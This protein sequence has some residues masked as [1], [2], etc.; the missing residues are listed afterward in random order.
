MTTTKLG[1]KDNLE[2]VA[3][4]DD[5]VA[6]AATDPIGNPGMNTM[7]DVA[8][9]QQSQHHA[10]L[11]W[12]GMSKVALPIVIK[13]RDLGDFNTSAYVETFVSLANPQV[14]GIH[15]S[16]LYLLLVEFAD[17]QVLTVTSLAAFLREKLSSHRDISDRACMHIAF[18]YLVNQP[19]LKSQYRGWKDY[20]ITIKM[21][22]DSRDIDIEMGVKVPYSSTCPCSSALAR[23]LLQQAFT[24][25]FKDCDSVDKQSMEQWLRSERGSVAT[26]HSQRSYA[27]VLVK[28]ANNLT[29]FPIYQLIDAIESVLKTPVQTAV[30][31]EDEQEFARL[32][33]ANQMFCEDAA[34]R[35]K[36]HLNRQPSF[37]DFW[38]R[39]EH[40]ESLHAHDAVAVA[41]KNVDNGYG[42]LLHR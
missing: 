7:P 39:V 32:N 4:R 37:T 1:R 36:S 28:L 3:K 24:E 16:R 15:M 31:R 23:Q 26:P 5:T 11:D 10:T 38:I 42:P 21:T 19:A 27:N 18:D 20:P 8:T 33:G 41:V 35:L 34:R 22:F 13:D 2:I 14:K 6:M 29:E 40:L 25:D 17:R 12:V 30:K 9:E